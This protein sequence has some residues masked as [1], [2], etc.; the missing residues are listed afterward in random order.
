MREEK[1]T[2]SKE[3]LIR[4]VSNL[5]KRLQDYDWDYRLDRFDEKIRSEKEETTSVLE[6]IEL[7]DNI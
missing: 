6:E 1:R 2:A 4:D 5:S 3:D 7:S